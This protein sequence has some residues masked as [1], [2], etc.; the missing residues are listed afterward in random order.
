LNVLTD[1]EQKLSKDLMHPFFDPIKI[2][3]NTIVQGITGALPHLHGT[4]LDLGCG[5]MPY[6]ALI[7]ERISGYV[8]TDMR[9]NQQ[10]PPMVCSDSLHLPFKDGSFDSILCTQV[11]EHVR[12]PFMLMSEIG[13]VL[14][15]G[16]CLVMTMPALWPL[17]EEPYD[18]FRYTKYGLI[19]LATVNNLEVVKVAERGGGILAIG[20]LFSALMYDTFGKKRWSRIPAK[21]LLGPM[22]SICKFIDSIFYYPKLTL[23][24][25]L[26]AQKKH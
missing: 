2:E 12:N 25:T 4:L 21:L 23:G 19:E 8:S 17:H 13:R 9:P 18:Y 1:K 6:A 14:R 10:F 20:Q 24:Y 16:G 15:T 26:I 22:L 5:S 11:I 3:S 7:E